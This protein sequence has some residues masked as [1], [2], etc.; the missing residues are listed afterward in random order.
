MSATTRSIL[1]I[2][3]GVIAIV[4]ATTAV[5]A[6][7]HLVGV[8]PPMNI[9]IDDRLSAIA[10]S[11]RV[12]ITVVGAYL[13]A[14]LAPG[15]PM[16]HALILGCVGTVMGALGAAATWDKGLGPHWY[17]IGLA[18]MALPECWAGGKLYQ[19]RGGA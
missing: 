17:P 9:P 8:F 12:V 15:K 18:V 1:A 4:V 11:Y 14:R 6:L 10:T 19:A 5:D 16:K 3:A 7:L 2:V 13:T